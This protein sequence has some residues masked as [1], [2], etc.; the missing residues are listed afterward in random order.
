MCK[1]YLKNG[2]FQRYGHNYFVKQ[3]VTTGTSY[4]VVYHFLHIANFHETC[5]QRDMFSQRPNQID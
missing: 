4:L 3:L 2:K 5:H 1:N